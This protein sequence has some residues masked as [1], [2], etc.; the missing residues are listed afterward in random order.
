MSPILYCFGLEWSLY[1]ILWHQKHVTDVKYISVC[2]NYNWIVT[3][4]LRIMNKV[5]FLQS[6]WDQQWIFCEGSNFMMQIHKE[7]L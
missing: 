2:I 6:E 3:I 7:F 4:G 5:L 1:D